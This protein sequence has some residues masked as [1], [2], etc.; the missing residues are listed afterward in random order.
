[1]TTVFNI[2]KG[3]YHRRI[4]LDL[5]EFTTTDA[6]GVVFR[7]R[8]RGGGALVVDDGAGDLDSSTRVSYQFQAPELD[9]AGS[10]QLEA[11]V[12]FPD[13]RETVPTTGFVT[14][15]IHEVLS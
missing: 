12:V 2:K 4:Q 15:T 6:T 1:M 5:T 14:V 13:G 3:D 9:T 8:P 7:M 11:S 10:F